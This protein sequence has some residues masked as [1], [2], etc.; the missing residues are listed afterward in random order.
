M[1]ALPEP[2]TVEVPEAH[3]AEWTRELVVDT[4]FDF[5][6]SVFEKAKLREDDHNKAV[7]ELIDKLRHEVLLGVCA[8]ERE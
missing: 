5:V 4:S 8:A 7:V 2:Q 3:N 6:S 1:K